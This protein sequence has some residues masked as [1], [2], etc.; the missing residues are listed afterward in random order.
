MSN[1]KTIREWAQELNEPERSSFLKQSK[2]LDKETDSLAM[3]LDNASNLLWD[4][5]KE[6]PTYWG[7]IHH[8]IS[9]GIYKKNFQPGGYVTGE[10]A[11]LH[12][13]GDSDMPAQITHSFNKS[14]FSEIRI[15]EVEE[16][17]SNLIS[18]STDNYYLELTKQLNE[19]LKSRMGNIK[20]ECRTIASLS[21][22]EIGEINNILRPEPNWEKLNTWEEIQYQCFTKTKACFSGMAV[23]KV[24]NYLCSIGIKMLNN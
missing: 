20:P 18:K 1:S 8:L 14:T 15:K 21:Q 6:G 7:G 4:S 13:K 5:S 11:R 16:I 3:A 17:I 9:K 10:Y 23:I 12:I 22:E 2:E 19:L 24:Y